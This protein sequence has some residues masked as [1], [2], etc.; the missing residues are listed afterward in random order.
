MGEDQPEPT[1]PLSLTME[2]ISSELRSSEESTASSR[3]LGI[4][5]STASCVESWC[6]ELNSTSARRKDRGEEV[7]DTHAASAFGRA[8]R[9]RPRV[10]PLK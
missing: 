6:A 10:T 1:S 4:A 5:T 8:A 9:S 3:A 7:K 2:A